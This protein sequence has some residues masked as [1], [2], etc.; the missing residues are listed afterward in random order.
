M[1]EEGRMPKDFQRNIL[2]TISKKA[3]ENKYEECR[4]ISSLSHASKILARIKNGEY[5]VEWRKK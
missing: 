1:Y 3:T 5:N 4:T 2:N